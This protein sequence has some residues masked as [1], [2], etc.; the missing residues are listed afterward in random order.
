MSDEII[1]LIKKDKDT[2]NLDLRPEDYPVA[3]QYILLRDSN[4]LKDFKPVLKTDP[5]VQITYIKTEEKIK[6]DLT[7]TLRNN[8]EAFESDTYI[9]N[10]TLDDY[11][12]ED[13]YQEKALNYAKEFITDTKNYKKG[14]YLQG[15]YG[16]G[17]SFLLAGLANELTKNNVDVVYAFVPDLIRSIKASMMDNKLEQKVNILKRCDV[18]ILDDL[19][20]E[21]MSSWFRDEIL[22]PILHYRLSA[23][24]SVFISSNYNKKILV[25]RIKLNDQT[26]LNALRIMQRINDLTIPIQFSEKFDNLEQNDSNS[27]E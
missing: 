25:E 6:K 24:L 23:N 19:G 11:I 22:L 3:Y 4:D 17:K 9:A 10:V 5:F 18:L 26:D 1:D 12:V 7:K 21:N 16:T 14:M 27:I 8:I 13:Q 15:P 20:G 2:K